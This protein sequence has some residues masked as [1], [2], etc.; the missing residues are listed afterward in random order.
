[1][2][3]KNY[4]YKSDC[5]KSLVEL[6][7]QKSRS[8]PLVMDKIYTIIKNWKDNSNKFTKFSIMMFPYTHSLKEYL[9]VYSFK[10]ILNKKKEKFEKIEY[11][12]WACDDNIIRTRNAK[13]WYIDATFKH[14][15]GFSELIVI[16]IIDEISKLKIPTFFIITNKKT[17]MTYYL[18]FQDIRA[19][20][21][22]G[23]NEKLKLVNYTTD[24][25]SAMNN[26]L[27]SIFPNIKRTG[28]YFHYKQ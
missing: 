23:F 2:N 8:F 12:I 25:E 17:E 27:A 7:N 5:V 20:L 28:C 14:P 13:Y 22:K 1:M 15:I 19:I 16:I 4:Y 3:S 11:A 21:E 6:Y 26:A 18:V 24:F 10:N 9:R